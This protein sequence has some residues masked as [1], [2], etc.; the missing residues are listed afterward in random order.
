MSNEQPDKEH[1]ASWRIFIGLVAFTALLWWVLPRDD[2]PGTNP[3]EG[4]AD[5]VA[6]TVAQ[7]VQEVASQPQQEPVVVIQVANDSGPVADARIEF[8]SV[9]KR[10]PPDSSRATIRDR[11]PFHRR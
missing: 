6:P 7:V 10:M 5:S 4:T 1:R 8:L 11:S 2:T 9:A 3:T